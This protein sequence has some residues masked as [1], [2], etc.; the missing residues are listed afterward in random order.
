MKLNTDLVISFK[1]GVDSIKIVNI[2]RYVNKIVI[3]SESDY[4]LPK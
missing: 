2:Y 4:I 1:E 3:I